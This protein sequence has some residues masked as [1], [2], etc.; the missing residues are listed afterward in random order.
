MFAFSK[1]AELRRTL[2]RAVV[3]AGARLGGETTGDSLAGLSTV[4]ALLRLAA[5]ANVVTDATALTVTLPKTGDDLD[6]RLAPLALARV[7]LEARWER[8]RPATLAATDLPAIAALEEG[9]LVVIL[10]LDATGNATVATADGDMSGPIEDIAATQVLLVGRADPINGDAEADERARIRSHPR[11]WLAGLF[12]GD[13]RRLMQMMVAAALLNLCGLAI[14]LYMRAIYDR[15]V[16]NLAVETMWALSLGV[17]IVLGFEFAFKHVR[18]TFVD[19]IGLRAGQIVQHRVMGGVLRAKGSQLRHSSGALMTALR[20]VEQLAILIPSAIVTFCIDLPYFAVFAL[21]IA[22]V[23]GWVVVA[24]VI[25]AMLLAVVGIA[26]ALGLKHAAGRATK[27]MQARHNL[28]VDVGEGLG[29]IKA[30]QA[31]GRFLKRWDTLS[32]HIAIT[33]RATREWSEGPGGVAALLVQLVTVMV[34]IV[35]VFQIKGG[36]LSVGGLVACTMLAGR[37]MVPVSGAITLLSRAYQSLAQFQGL[38]TLLALEPEV[39]SGDPAL[40]GRAIR[41]EL[42]FKAAAYSF[43]GTPEPVLSG[44]NFTIR[45]GE[46]VALIGRSGSGKTTLLQMLAG[47]AAPTAGRLHVDGHDITHYSAGQLRARIGYAAQDAVLFD[48]SV[49]DNVLMGVDK[50]NEQLFERACAAAGVDNFARRLPDG[51]G[52][53]VGPRG[54]RLSGGQ[55]QSLILARALVR[56]PHLLLLDEPTEAMDLLTEQ[57]M[58]ASIKAWLPNRTLI[59]ATHRPA[60]LSLVERVIWLEDGKV[61]A[62]QPVDAVLSRLNRQTA[63]NAA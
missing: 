41:G 51:Y 4:A 40:G 43:P 22:Y 8:R 48:L 50:V 28:I 14:P 33:G 34:V 9:G 20:D 35:G 18:S 6:A 23:G 60:L 25:G 59:L 46:R 61:V 58:I 5:E 36:D 63:A 39:E 47:M 38:S 24:P 3:S 17:A 13:R 1:I 12:L 37:A 19:A 52:F 32:D 15:V 2:G 57:S 7:G 10:A 21:L 16:P 29:T 45:P 49:R 44:L 31:E 55:R 30:A 53:K 26:G 11:L 62:D 56:N 27:L 42:S 54:D